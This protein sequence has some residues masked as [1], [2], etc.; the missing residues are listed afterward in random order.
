MNAK[1]IILLAVLLS[2][3]CAAPSALATPTPTDIPPTPTAI[4][5]AS[6][7]ARV[8]ATQ[9]VT[10]TLPVFVAVTGNWYCRETPS[11][12]AEVI[13]VVA[14]GDMIE[15][16]SVTHAGWT[17]VHPIGIEGLCWMAGW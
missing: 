1:T 13:T 4:P 6:P 11:T 7:T 8:T 15:L 14:H 5:Q 9:G 10:P 2:L 17:L 12:T 16:T 3:S